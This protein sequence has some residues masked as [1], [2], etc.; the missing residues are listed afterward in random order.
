MTRQY[1]LVVIGGGAAGIAAARAGVRRGAQ[2]LMVQD[3][4]IGGD[5]TFTGC[6]PS[7]ALI[8]AARRGASF[9]EAMTS[10]RR[11]VEKIAATEDDAVF[12]KEGIDVIHGQA[13]LASPT[14]VNVEGD[15]VMAARVV[16][17]AGAGPVV[18]PIPGLEAVKHLTNE[19]IF[20]L[21]HQPERLVVLGGGAIG[22]EL[23]QAFRRLGSEVTIVE[24]ADR[25]LPPEEPEASATITEVLAREGTEVRTGQPAVAVRATSRGDISVEVESGPPITGD[26][27]LVAVGRRP[28]TSTLG[29]EAA[30]VDVDARGSVVTDEALRT[31]V[32]NIWAVGD[33]TGRLPFTHAADEMGRIAAAN[34]LS[35]R[36][37]TRFRASRVPW[38]TFTDPEAGRIGMTEAEA[39]AHGGQV[40]YLPFSEVDRAIT[41]GA[42]DGF[43]KLIA[44]PRRV[45]GNAGGGRVLGATVVAPVGGE[46]IHEAALAMRT[47]MFTGRLAQTVHAYPTWSTAVRSAAAQFFMEV[48]GRRARP[49]RRD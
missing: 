13:R 28:A 27:L 25:I 21:A 9:G 2:T 44:G 33:V 49:A 15:R 24:A 8:A 48:D 45:L 19:T 3:G 36:G 10:V 7:K 40:A 17:A 30:G 20:E 16:I 39:A 46:L 18:P 34:A 42:T 1:D 12:A 32:R 37:R 31:T 43:V 14:E 4:P 5:C 23:A 26:E 11:A 41:E 38:V 35:R 22:C 6:V 47:A 29:L